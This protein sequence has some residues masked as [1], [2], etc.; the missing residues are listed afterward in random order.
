MDEEDVEA[1]Q[2]EITNMEKLY[3]ELRAHRL[4]ITIDRTYELHDYSED[5]L[6]L[7]E[8]IRLKD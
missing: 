2:Q 7:D 1:L 4:D 5:K 6:T 3:P 8:E